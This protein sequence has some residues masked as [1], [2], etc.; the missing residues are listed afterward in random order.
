MAKLDSIVQFLNN[1]L[2]PGEFPDDSAYNGLQVE[3]PQQDIRKIALAVDAGLSVLEKAVAQEADLL[4]V[5]HGF[6]WG[7]VLPISGAFGRKARLL[8]TKGCSLYASHLPLDAQPEVGNNFEMARF[9]GLEQ[10]EGFCEYKGNKIG[11]KG[12]LASAKPLDYF[13]QRANQMVGA[14]P[15]VTL[16][17]GKSTISSVGIVTGAAAFALES[18]ARDGLDLFISGEPK[19]NVY[20]EA[21]ELGINALF[22][23]HYATET[24]GVRALGSRLQKNYD[25]QTFFI[26]EPT[27]I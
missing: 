7:T 10:I 3:A 21:K 12:R 16:P 20:H 9:F 19:Q 4:I 27:G 18:A 15:L 11:A 22:A 25:V 5:H 6:F 1:L 26:D 17:F 24:F 13:S 2:P 23:G 14:S 8:L